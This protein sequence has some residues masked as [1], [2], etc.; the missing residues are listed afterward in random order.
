MA[1][2]AKREKKERKGAV[3]IT[4]GVIMVLSAVGLWG[5]NRYDAD[6]ADKASKEIV[7]SLKTQMPEKQSSQFEAYPQ[8]K[9]V[10]VTAEPDGEKWIGI[11]KIPSLEVELPVAEEFSYDNLNVG[12]CRC[13]GS[14]YTNDLVIAAHNFYNHFGRLDNLSIGDEIVFYDFEGKVHYYVVSSQEIVQPTDVDGMYIDPDDD[15]DLTLFT[16]TWSGQT[17]F[18]VRCVRKQ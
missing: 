10:A 14:A 1:D 7:V 2:K 15:W 4:L 13:N 11:V 8:R 9:M 16:C 18:T 3:C 5:Y 6:R 17:R 12:A